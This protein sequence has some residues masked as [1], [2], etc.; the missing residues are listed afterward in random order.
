MSLGT[1]LVGAALFLF[2]AAYVGSPLRRIKLDADKVIEQWVSG[3][4]TISKEALPLSGVES[5]QLITTVVDA[6]GP[7]E[8]DEAPVNFCPQCGRR[9]EVD[10]RFCPGC[11]TQLPKGAAR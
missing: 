7:A 1:Y 9:V 6:I 4:R 10:H 3:A 8:V 5:T 11:G 2:I